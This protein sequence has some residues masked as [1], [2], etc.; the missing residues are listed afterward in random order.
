MQLHD[1]IILPMIKII[2]WDYDAL[3]FLRYYRVKFFK[4]QLLFSIY[5][6]YQSSIYSFS[7]SI[8]YCSLTVINANVTKSQQFNLKT[9]VGIWRIMHGRIPCFSHGQP[10][11]YLTLIKNC[12]GKRIFQ[13]GCSMQDERIWSSE[14]GWLVNFSHL[15]LD[16]LSSSSFVLLFL[17]Y[18]GFSCI[19]HVN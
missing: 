11:R 3:Q 6:I 4:S 7:S 16:F 1:Y 17:S 14:S 10:S 9:I 8:F 12:E 5:H 2:F 13:K 18:W 19:L 15:F